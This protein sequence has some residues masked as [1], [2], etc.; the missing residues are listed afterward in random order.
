MV[1]LIY[2]HYTF[3]QAKFKKD[4][5]IMNQ[6]ARQKTTSLVQHDFYKLLSNSNFEIDCRNNIDN[7]MLEPIYDEISEISYIK[8][9]DT[10]ST[11]K[12]PAIFI[13]SR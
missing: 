6:K 13:T 12:T 8:K 1:T 11:M 9:F 2:E 7:C 3:E 5:L 10:I 4:F